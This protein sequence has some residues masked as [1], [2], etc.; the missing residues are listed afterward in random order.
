MLWDTEGMYKTKVNFPLWRIVFLFF[1]FSHCSV[2]FMSEWFLLCCSHVDGSSKALFHFK[3]CSRRESFFFGILWHYK[4][5][6]H[7][8]SL[9]GNST[10]FLLWDHLIFC[11][12]IYDYSRVGVGLKQLAHLNQQHTCIDIYINLCPAHPWIKAVYSPFPIEC[13][14]SVSLEF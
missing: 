3:I 4:Q 1:V 7:F 9:Q 11:C 10:L 5:A 2:S 13:N 8:V 12:N 14:A 6:S